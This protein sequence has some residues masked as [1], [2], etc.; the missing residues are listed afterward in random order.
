MDHWFGPEN[1]LAIC[2]GTVQFQSLLFWIIGSGTSKGDLAS[3]EIE[4]SI[5]V[6]L[7]HW[8]GPSNPRHVKRSPYGFQSLLFW[9]IGS[10]MVT[11]SAF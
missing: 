7:D 1:G 4:V 11:V 6:V 5:L 3:G 2:F 9:I 8:F 10:G